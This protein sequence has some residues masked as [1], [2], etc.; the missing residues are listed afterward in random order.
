MKDREVLVQLD[1]ICKY[2]KL[3]KKKDLKALDHISLS[4]YKGEILGVVGE[5]GCGKSTLGK[6]ISRIETPTEGYVY[7]NGE[8]RNAPVSGAMNSEHKLT[9]KKEKEYCKNVQVVFQDPYSSLNPRHTAGYSVERGLKIH[10]LYKGKEKERLAQLLAMVGLPEETADRYPHEFSGGQ[11]QRICI[12]RALSVEPEFLICDEPISALDVSIQSQI[13]NLLIS[14]KEAFGLTMLFISHDLSV[15][16][17]ICDRVV[18]MYLGTVVEVAESEEIYEHPLHYYTKALLSAV[19]I[20]DPEVEKER[21]RILLKGDIPS[22]VDAPK[23]CTF[24]SRCPYSDETCHNERPHLKE[25][26]PGHQVAC[27]HVGRIGK[28]TAEEAY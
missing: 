1:D 28:N 14:M 7:Y 11:R 19:P 24:C 3:E 13:I 4:V 12:A 22:P 16:K 9:K 27:H 23:G 5:S 17:Y 8:K 2:F 15:V 26:R 6:V 18:V 25:Y 20:A 21:K 10:G